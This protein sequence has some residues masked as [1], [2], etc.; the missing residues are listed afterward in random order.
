[1]CEY[2]IAD[3]PI[4]AHT[5]LDSTLDVVGLLELDPFLSLDRCRYDDQGN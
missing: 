5:V 4:S 3:D 2:H 1:M